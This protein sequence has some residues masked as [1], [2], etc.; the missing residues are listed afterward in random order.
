LCKACFAVHKADSAA[1]VL[2]IVVL[3]QLTTKFVERSL[4]LGCEWY[5]FAVVVED[6]QEASQVDK[7]IWLFAVHDGC[8]AFCRW[9][10]VILVDSILK[11]LD[12]AQAKAAFADL[13]A[14]SVCNR[15]STMRRCSR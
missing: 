15:E 11:V 7:G 12:I 3:P 13:G 2:G 5:A 8:D 9:F 1:V 10:T 6:A 14:Q 4:M